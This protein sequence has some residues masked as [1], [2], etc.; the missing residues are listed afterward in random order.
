MLE[1]NFE[2]L[3]EPIVRLCERLRSLHAKFPKL[4]SFTSRVGREAKFVCQWA[5]GDIEPGRA[6]HRSSSYQLAHAADVSLLLL[7]ELRSHIPPRKDVKIFSNIRWKLRGCLG[8]IITWQSYP[9]NFE[10][11][12]FECTRVLDDHLNGQNFVNKVVNSIL[13]YLAR[14]MWGYFCL[15]S[16]VR[17]GVRKAKY[18]F[19]C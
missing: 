4:F 18:F 12:P 2:P 10:M 6:Q 19:A 15:I 8:A 14:S 5:V 17:K 7:Q 13:G 11:A 3:I 1:Y 9:G 16:F